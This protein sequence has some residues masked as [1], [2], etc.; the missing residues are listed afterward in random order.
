MGETADRLVK[1]EQR[2]L[3]E[4]IA[5]LDR[6]MLRCNKRLTKEILNRNKARDMCLSDTYS[7]LIVSERNLALIKEDR[8]SLMA[9]RNELYQYRIIVDAEDEKSTDT[10][11]MKIGLHTY[12]KGEKIY[13]YSW[14][15]DVCRHYILDNS[16]VDYKGT[17]VDGDGK[18][19]TDYRLKLKRDIKLSF[20]KVKD[21]SQLYPLSL[22]GQEEALSDA[23]LKELISRR[24]ETEF[25]NIVFSIQKQ[26]GEIIQAPFS[27]NLLVQGCAGSGKSMIM[28]HRLPILLYDNPGSLYKNNLYIISPSEA[29]IQMADDMRYQLEI[30]DLKMGT[31]RQYYDYVI[32]KYGHK[33]SEYGDVLLPDEQAGAE[34]GRVYSEKF[35]STMKHSIDDMID[36]DDVD[37]TEGLTRYGLHKHRSSSALPKDRIAA[38][39]MTIED[40]VGFDSEAVLKQAPVIRNAV[41]SFEAL[42]RMLAGLKTITI[43]SI[44]KRR[45]V[46]QDELGKLYKKMSGLDPV[47][48]KELYERRMTECGDIE[49]RISYLSVLENEVDKDEDY[50]GK[51]TET[52]KNITGMPEEYSDANVHDIKNTS[53]MYPLVVRK[54]EYAEFVMEYATRATGIEDKYAEY[55]GSI[56]EQADKTFTAAQRLYDIKSSLLD[57]RYRDSLGEARDYY[58]GL[59]KNI[60]RDLYKTTMQELEK[61]MGK[62][63]IIGLQCSPY[64]FTQI[65]YICNGM[66]NAAKESL[67]S[68]DEAQ[69]LAPVELDLIKNVNDNKVILNL[70]GDVR[71]HIEGTKGIDHWYEFADVTGFDRYDMKENYRNANE[72]TE[73]CNK[74]FNMEMRAISLN[75]N[76]VHGISSWNSFCKTMDGLLTGSEE[77]KGIK[78]VIVKDDHCVEAICSVFDKQSGRISRLDSKH[79]GVHRTKWN[80]IT[81]AQSKGIEFGTVVVMNR[82]MRRNEKYIAYTRALDELFVYDGEIPDEYLDGEKKKST[83]KQENS[84]NSS[85]VIKK[86]EKQGASIASATKITESLSKQ[87]SAIQT[88]GNEPVH[89]KKIIIIRKTHI[90]DESKETNGEPSQG[91]K[92]S[93]KKDSI[94]S[95]V[96]EQKRTAVGSKPSGPIETRTTSENNNIKTGIKDKQGSSGSIKEYFESVGIEVIDKRDRGGCLWI[97]GERSDISKY[98]NEAVTRF[99]ISGSYGAG[100]AT[101]HR[102][103]WFTKSSK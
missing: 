88:Q 33:P 41:E 103:G 26:Q 98:V 65:L 69:G 89:K 63:K 3:D 82:T 97:V 94:S 43:R 34:M 90:E 77:R 7:M 20:D 21:T 53:I 54:R 22:A 64:L 1:E 99:K 4:L 37:L 18:Y 83:S 49:K 68:I 87:Q 71:Q 23:F 92:S 25:R 61:D 45:T 6:E 76:G 59:K 57:S 24:N 93:I 67:I 74:C 52:G 75:G 13:V 60:E 101:G 100:H 47:A 31:L 102:N 2:I 48:D 12:L 10:L 85:P 30:E 11:D 79:P 50:F 17:V 29:Y 38:D 46:E 96:K 16:S 32:L 81:V 62:K 14:K 39:I 72:I 70:Y 91:G 78:A 42:R 86:N 95:I 27:K 73:Y 51:A 36:K 8:R 80:I 56:Y 84:K 19:D 66:P 5:E 55:A 40:I 35:I 28:L 15:R 9:S 44:E 58:V